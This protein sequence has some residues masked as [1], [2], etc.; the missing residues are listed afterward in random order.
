[1][2][3]KLA[4]YSAVQ[5]RFK[6]NREEKY[7]VAVENM[8]QGKRKFERKQKRC[9]LCRNEMEPMQKGDGSYSRAENC[10]TVVN[11][12]HHNISIYP[13]RS[14]GFLANAFSPFI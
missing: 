11:K 5:G 7:L 4:S 10:E 8:R 14:C 1:M 3:F 6:R 12:D 9:N 13:L 2:L